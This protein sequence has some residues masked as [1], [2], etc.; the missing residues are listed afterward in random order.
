MREWHKFN[1]DNPEEFKTKTLQWAST[2]SHFTFFNNNGLSYPNSPFT[3]IVAIGAAKTLLFDGE[4]DFQLLKNYCETHNNWLIGYLSYDLKNQIESLESNNKDFTNF[5]DIYFYEPKHI[6][7]FNNSSVEIQSFNTP[8]SIYHE[9]VN[10]THDEINISKGLDNSISNNL[11]QQITHKEYIESVEKLRKHIIE[12]DIYEANFCMGFNTNIPQL[13]TLQLYQNL[14]EKSPTPFSV[15]QKINHNY[16][17]C[18]SPERFLKKEGNKLT[19]QPIKGTIK[20]GESLEGDNIQIQ[21]LRNSEKE[22]AENMMIVD[23]VRN[24]LARSCIAGSVK[25]EEMFGIYPFKHL[26]QM[27]S[28]I[29][30]ELRD[31]LHFIDAI[32]NAFPM[33]SMTGA[34]KIKVM[35]LIEK[36]E[37][38]KRGLF[39][40]TIGYIS[41]NQDFDFN[42]VIRSIFYNG[43]TS[44]LSFQAGSAITYDSDPEQ[45][46]E[47]C[48]LKVKAIKEVLGI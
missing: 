40:G 23:L 4:N 45:E 5:P 6:I 38:N 7:I 35:E 39:S 21:L 14:I 2:F 46:Y 27:I 8:Q 9:I 17:L 29:S 3:N 15:Y 26:F 28:T 34:P 48:M 1:V 12:G 47:E 32:K 30:G 25:V 42:V 41:P 33:G 13:N 22:R 18:A 16:L 36:Y 20:R 19:S 24:D 11:K 10:Y 37:K 44:Q 43:K 31:D